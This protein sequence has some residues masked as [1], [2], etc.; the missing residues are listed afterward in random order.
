MKKFLLLILLSIMFTSC[1]EELINNPASNRA[2]DTKLFL[3][4]D[5]SISSQPSRISLHWSGD[6]PD[7]FVTGFYFTWDGINWIFTSG[8]D[9]LFALQIGAVDTSYSFRVSAVDNSGNG[10][11]DSQVFQNN[12]NFGAEPFKDGNNNGLYDA[13]ESFIDIGLIDPT[14][15][16]LLFPIKNTAPIIFWNVLSFLPD[17]SFPAMTFGWEAEDLDGNETIE[18]INISL[19]DT[20]K[21]LS[22]NGSIRRI[23]IRTSDFSSANPLMEILVDGNPGNIIPEKLEGLKLN[24]DNIFYVQAVDISGAKSPF[25]QLPDENK[26]WYVKKPKGHLVIIDNY[27]AADNA[28]EFYSRMMDSLSL[29][30]G[31]DFYDIQTQQ[32]PFL[33]LT[34]L[35]TIKLFKYAIWF[36]DNNPS[37]DLASASTQKY[38]DAGGKILFSLQFPQSVDLANIQGFLPIIPDSSD[39]R[40]SILAGVKI[41]ADSTQPLYPT[42]EVTSSL[43]RVRS[44]YLGQLGVIPVYYFPNNELKG[45]I[46]FS[47]STNSLFFIG[48]PLHRLNGGNANV[49][50]LLQK[51]L[52]EDFNLPAGG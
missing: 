47:N 16:E 10:I 29:A 52:F 41:S 12:I 37:L 4:P 49:K 44:F 42:L 8:N 24:A 11:Y 13:G 50:T 6:D 19:N 45:Y 30:N 9:S 33:N 20:T 36:S 17:T 51:I 40:N 34:F 18:W 46:G 39:T 2:P 7:G 23:T 32:P 35:E 31:F 28:N 3:Y 48:L 38:L 5:S 43:F 27:S 26:S 22:L 25:I 21:Y 15:A 14:P 1:Y